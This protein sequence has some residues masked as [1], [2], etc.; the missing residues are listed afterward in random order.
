MSNLIR[1]QAA[2]RGKELLLT[3]P[4]RNPE[5]FVF[6]EITVAVG[7]I[8]H[9]E[10]PFDDPRAEAFILKFS[11]AGQRYMVTAEYHEQVA[12]TDA[13]AEINALHQALVEALET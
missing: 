2:S 5:N 3:S 4:K 13:D 6:R 1:F 8:S 11:L 12:K 10:A 9:I 7:H